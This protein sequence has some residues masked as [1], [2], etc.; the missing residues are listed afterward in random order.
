MKIFNHDITLSTLDSNP[1]IHLFS[2]RGI[3]LSAPGDVVQLHPNLAVD[4][5]AVREHYERI[6][7]AHSHNILWT[8]DFNVLKQQPSDNISVYFFGHAFD[9]KRNCAQMLRDLDTE[10]YQV[11]Q[12]MNSKNK[13]VELAHELGVAVP[14]TQCFNHRGEL[15][16]LEAFAYPC[17]VKL[18]VSD[19]GVGICRCENSADLLAA[20]EQFPQDKPFQ[21]QAEIQALAFLNLQYRITSQGL[22]RVLVSEQILDGC[23]HGGNR[24]PTLHQPWHVV[25]PMAQWMYDHGMKGTF[26]F[27]VAVVDTP[28]GVD[29]LAIECNPRFNGSSYPTEMAKRLEIDSWCSETLHVDCHSLHDLN[30]EELEFNPTTKTGIVLVNWGTIQ[31][32]KLT[33]LLAG[34]PEQQTV[35]SQA[36]RT[37]W[38]RKTVFAG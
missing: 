14:P 38:S 12:H 2:A 1:G 16:N 11:V 21:I 19:H 35:L 31:V 4:W 5:P 32:G 33:V 24:Y 34:S 13:F 30:L 6:G 9:H 7:L 26:G 18:A 25:E 20:I 22:E 10:W 37:R 28:D 23:V 29:Y 36:M 27:D 8:T 3:G 15:G 17:Y